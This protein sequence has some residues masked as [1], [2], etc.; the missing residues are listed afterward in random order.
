MS[1]T[2]P[3]PVA[4]RP[5]SRTLVAVLALFAV[6]VIWGATFVWMKQGLSA[7]EAKLGSGHAD[8]AVAVFMLLR[9]GVAALIMF[10]CVPSVR[11]D[12]ARCH[13]HSGR[14]LGFLLFLGFALQMLGLGVVSPAVSA[15]LTSLY[16][17]FTALISAVRAR[18]GIRPALAVGVVCATLGAGMI[19]GRPELS[20][21]LGEFATVGCAFVFALHILLTDRVTR[22]EAPLPVTFTSF[23]WTALASAILLFW[24]MLGENAPSM[25]VLVELVLEPAFLWP[26]ALSCVFATVLAISLMNVFQRELDPVRAAILYAF[27]PIWAAVFAIALG[28]DRFTSWLVI[29]GAILL[30]GNLISELGQQRKNGQNVA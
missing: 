5:P 13:W 15:F 6:T 10:L 19:R 27:E 23:A 4:T 28:L 11:R 22:V 12:L 3:T 18:R 25:R 30:A 20:I 8:A 26:L 17:L 7:A 21:T 2:S 9:F 14:T 16:V 29:G 1:D 24:T